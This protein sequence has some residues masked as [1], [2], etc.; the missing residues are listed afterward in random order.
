V[1]EQ[2]GLLMAQHS[3]LRERQIDIPD[4]TWNA[5]LWHRFPVPS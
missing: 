2:A 4:T 1:A 5:H 3:S